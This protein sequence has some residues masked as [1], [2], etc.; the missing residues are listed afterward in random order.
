MVFLHP[1]L[2]KF[3]AVVVRLILLKFDGVKSPNGSRT[4]DKK[5]SK[6][7]FDD[8]YDFLTTFTLIASLSWFHNIPKVLSKGILSISRLTD[9]QFADRSSWDKYFKISLS[10]DSN[11]VQ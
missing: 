4:E 10:F 6:P 3:S 2:N 8:E 7:H 1:N 9:W 11:L 5:L